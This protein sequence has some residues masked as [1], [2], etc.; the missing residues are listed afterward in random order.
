MTAGL[1]S[2]E[3]AAGRKHRGNRFENQGTGPAVDRGKRYPGDDRLGRRQIASGEGVAKITRAAG[4]HDEP[5]V[6]NSSEQGREVPVDFD[7]QESC[8]RPHGVEDRPGRAA[9]AG[10]QLDHQPRGSNPCDLDNTAL[11]K[12]RAG[13]D[14]TDLPG[15][16]QELLKEYNPVIESAA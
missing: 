3:A 6:T 4:M 1:V 10:A 13:S 12:T 11:E 15:V 7:H 2:H 14:G 5:W 16:L 8:V 9:G